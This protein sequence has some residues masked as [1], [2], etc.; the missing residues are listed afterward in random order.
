MMETTT[1]NPVKYFIGALYSFAP[2]LESCLQVV[3]SFLGP[4][5]LQSQNFPFEVTT[6]YNKEMGTPIFRRFYGFPHLAT[7]DQLASYKLLTN[8]IESQ[9]L[10]DGQRKV[11][12]D[13]GYLDYDKVVL[14]S[15]KYGLNK[16]YLDQGIYADLALH[17]EKGQYYPYPWAF[18]D[19]KSSLYNPFFLKLR[20]LYKQQ[21]KAFSTARKA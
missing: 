6:Y 10:I 21:L 14:G 11:N 16:I 19:F 20:T 9:H 12:L 8:S 5:D 2:L 1:I 13:I 3:E 17:Y 18:L 4:A 15:A 7:P